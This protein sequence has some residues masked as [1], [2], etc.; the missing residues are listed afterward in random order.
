MTVSHGNAVYVVTAKV[1][2]L[3]WNDTNF[4][5]SAVCAK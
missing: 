2:V 3:T 5:T 4:W 1:S